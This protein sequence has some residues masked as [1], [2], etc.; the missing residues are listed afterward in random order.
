[1]IGHKL[2]SFALL[3][4]AA[5]LFTAIWITGIAQAE[6]R[7]GVVVDYDITVDTTWSGNGNYTICAAS[8]GE[9]K[10]K[11]GATLT[12]ESGAIVYFADTLSG[13]L[14]SGETPIEY[15]TVESGNLI[16]DGVKFTVLPGR[17][18]RGWG[19]IIARASGVT[20]SNLS[21]TNCIFEY[22]GFLGG[23]AAL[24]QNLRDAV[25]AASR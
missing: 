11:N 6:E 21:F 5:I 15:L 19:G 2:R 20:P 10:I 9:P 17:E 12:I 3:V 22:T 7:I 8:N 1:M 24:P 25:I 18:A 14:I 4:G 13:N 16:A 23:I